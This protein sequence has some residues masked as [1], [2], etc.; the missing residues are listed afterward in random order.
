MTTTERSQ[1]DKWCQR[2]TE[3]KTSTIAC[4][5]SRRAGHYRPYASVRDA[6]E[7]CSQSRPNLMPSQ[8]LRQIKHMSKTESSNK[9]INYYRV[10][11]GF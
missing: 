5:W 2:V 6:I 10:L 11:S 9:E 3:R 7:V 4:S 8:I 1:R